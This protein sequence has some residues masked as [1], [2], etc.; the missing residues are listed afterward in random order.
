MTRQTALTYYEQAFQEMIIPSSE[1]LKTEMLIAITG[2]NALLTILIF[3]F[4]KLQYIMPVL[5][6]DLVMILAVGV[7]TIFVFVDYW[8]NQQASYHNAG[9]INNMKTFNDYST[10]CGDELNSLD[11]D[12]ADTNMGLPSKYVLSILANCYA[13][14]AQ[15]GLFGIITTICLAMNK[16]CFKEPEEEQGKFK[17]NG[18]DK[19]VDDYNDQ[20]KQQEQ[21]NYSLNRDED[22]HLLNN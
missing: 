16:K 10:R 8:D 19:V 2:L 15:T 3:V 5:I 20:E 6:L 14:F 22:E 9:V 4:P 12:K 18:G 11:I 21:P 17:F 1:D 7:T 13:I